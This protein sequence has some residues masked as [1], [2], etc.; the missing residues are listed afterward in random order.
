MFLIVPRGRGHLPVQL[1]GRARVAIGV[2]VEV[3]LVVLQWRRRTIS[4]EEG[5]K[6]PTRERMGTYIL[7]VVPGSSLFN[8]GDDLLSLGSETEENGKTSQPGDTSSDGRRSE[9][10]ALLL[11]D[12]V[13]DLLGD[14]VLLRRCGEDGGSVLCEKM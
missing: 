5:R 13:P 9:R 7:G 14:G 4:D 3:E 12:L 1:V 8:L 10:H 6:T 11:L 2:D